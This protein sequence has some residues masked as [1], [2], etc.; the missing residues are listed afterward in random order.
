ME[1]IITTQIARNWFASKGYGETRRGLSGRGATNYII[2]TRG[3]SG[4]RRV[5]QRAE[6][7][8]D[9]WSPVLTP[10]SRKLYKPAG[11]GQVVRLTSELYRAAEHAAILYPHCHLLDGGSSHVTS[12]NLACDKDRLISRRYTLLGCVI[13]RVSF[14]YFE[15]YSL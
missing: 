8:R 12:T 10:V 4:Y 3:A 2:W 1:L 6:R 5:A 9:R 7:E 11:P 15:D 13:L 14:S